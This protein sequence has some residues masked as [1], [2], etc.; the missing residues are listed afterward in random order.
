MDSEKFDKVV[1]D[2]LYDELDELTRASA[3]RHIEQSRRAK[4][5]Y[6]EL[7]ATREVGTLPLVE[8]PED[9]ERRIL[10]AEANA[11]AERPLRQRLGTLVSIAAS[12][13]MR[14]QLGMAALLMLM[15]GSSLLLLRGKPGETSNVLI[16]ER[17]VQESEHETV[18]VVPVTPAAP[19]AKATAPSEGQRG[20]R[21]A[22]P[23]PS[24]ADG[25]PSEQKKKSAATTAR[26]KTSLGYDDSAGAGSF[27][28]APLPAAPAA[29]APRAAEAA[30]KGAAVD[31]E[32]SARDE[33]APSP[34][35]AAS[36]AHHEAVRANP[37]SPSEGY[38]ATWEAAECYRELGSYAQARAAYQSLTLVP[39]Y[40]D[41]ARRALS[42]LPRPVADAPAATATSR[43][44][45][46]PAK[47]ASAPATES[48]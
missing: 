43:A 13:A 7:R 16:T 4:G 31:L 9:L 23:E 12:Y 30:G 20:T 1:L 33:A 38:A 46:K 14:P 32:A 10:E 40:A 22:A 48:R 15:L 44:A 35:C 17:G 3:I 29:A 25:V 8:P 5:L 41:R 19:E 6:S 36:L 28:P 24:R 27:A 18:T 37:P 11:R 34:G 45:A 2:L 21:M 39:E 26:S 42:E 47:K